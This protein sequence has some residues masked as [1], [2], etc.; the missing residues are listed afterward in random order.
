MAPALTPTPMALNGSSFGA[1]SSLEDYDHAHEYYEK[2]ASYSRSSIPVLP[3]MGNSDHNMIGLGT[4][5]RYQSDNEDDYS[6]FPPVVQMNRIP[7]GG[8]YEGLSD[9][10]HTSGGSDMRMAGSARGATF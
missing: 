10:E 3:P 4:P 6:N 8:N 2:D 5:P 7:T 1:A 9:D